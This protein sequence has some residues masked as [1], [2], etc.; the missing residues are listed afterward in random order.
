VKIR[1]VLVVITTVLASAVPACDIGSPQV[2]GTPPVVQMMP[3]LPG[4]R[5]VEGRSVQEYIAGLAQGASLLSGNPQM[6]LLIELADQAISCYREV[7]AVNLRIY[8]DESFPLSSGAI[9]IADRNRLT[10]PQT[11]FRCIGGQMITSSAEPTLQPCA[12]SYTLERD[13]NTFY[14]VY[15]GTTQEIC[16]AFCANLEG[17]TGY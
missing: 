17:C 4:Y 3:N 12:H 1:L 7:G 6:L 2:T 8:S 14:F 11:L 9:A 16:Q 13:D 15:V 5:V 10:D